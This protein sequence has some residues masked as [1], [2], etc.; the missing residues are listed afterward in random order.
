VHAC[1]CACVHVCM[2]ACVHVCMCACVHVRGHAR[3]TI[4][5]C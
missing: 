1:V 5:A 3:E 2:Y 4:D